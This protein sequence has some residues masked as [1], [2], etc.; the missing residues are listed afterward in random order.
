MTLQ[1]SCE[2][3]I[4]DDEEERALAELRI[5]DASLARHHDG[6]RAAAERG[7]A[8]V[9]LALSTLLSLTRPYSLC[10]SL[11]SCDDFLYCSWFVLL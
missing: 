10:M 7:E 3:V 5:L 9:L 1:V 11:C 8:C 4:P 2:D 6:I